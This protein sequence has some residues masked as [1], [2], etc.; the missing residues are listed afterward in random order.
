MVT[1]NHEQTEMAT[2]ETF[3]H[4]FCIQGQ[5]YHYLVKSDKQSLNALCW[6]NLAD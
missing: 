6:F 4:I 1:D 2:Q 3:P 5:D